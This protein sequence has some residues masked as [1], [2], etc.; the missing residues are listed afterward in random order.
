MPHVV[1]GTLR[2]KAWRAMQIKVKFTLSDLVRSAVPVG[3][4]AK[5]PRNNIGRYVNA[6]TAA[7]ILMEMKRRTSP[8]SPTSNGEKRWV[9]VRD[10]G[11]LPP[12][13]REKGGVYDPNSKTTI[14]GPVVQADSVIE[15][16]A[17]HVE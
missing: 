10:L 8:A 17:G 9:L 15:A 7:G 11:R 13:A 5:D 3:S 14:G 4:A 1:Q 12:V 2:Q 16:E 6:L